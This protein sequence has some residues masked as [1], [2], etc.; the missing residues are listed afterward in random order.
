MFYKGEQNVATIKGAKRDDLKA[1][2][3][4]HIAVSSK[5][6]TERWWIWHFTSREESLD[7]IVLRVSNNIY[8]LK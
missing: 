1:T 6:W 2:I 4:E 7:V 5:A 8:I 3:A